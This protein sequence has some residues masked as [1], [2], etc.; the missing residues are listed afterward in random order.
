MV[1]EKFQLTNLTQNFRSRAS[2]QFRKVKKI[3]RKFTPLKRAVIFS[4]FLNS[5]KLS[6]TRISTKGLLDFDI[7]RP[8]Y[9]LTVASGEDIIIDLIIIF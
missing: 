8:Q 6:L 4:S 9:N 5:K 3:H 1:S 2:Y 7:L